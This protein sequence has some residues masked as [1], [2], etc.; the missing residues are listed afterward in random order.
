MQSPARYTH[1]TRGDGRQFYV[2]A[3]DLDAL[4][5]LPL[6]EAHGLDLHLA[7]GG[8]VRAAMVPDG[9]IYL[10]NPRHAQPVLPAR[11]ITV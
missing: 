10:G 6:G 8:T 3:D 5:A 7:G 1:V 4:A 2:R 11:W 9:T